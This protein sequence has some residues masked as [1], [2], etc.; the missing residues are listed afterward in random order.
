MSLRDA[1]DNFYERLVLDA[2]DATREE[3]DTAD[4]L[5]DVMCVALNRLPARYY[6]HTIDMMFYLA[7]EE[8][9][10]MK[11]KSLA[12]VRQARDFVR[13]HQRE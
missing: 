1:I 3:S 10:E 4:Y 8:L 13:Q 2:I 11:E 12:A 5:T 6:R 7:D 9:K